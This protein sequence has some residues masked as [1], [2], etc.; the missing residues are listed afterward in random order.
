MPKATSPAHEET[1]GGGD[2]QDE[3]DEADNDDDDDDDD[4]EAD[5]ARH[6]WG[7]NDDEDGYRL[8]SGSAA[9]DSRNWAHRQ[10]KQRLERTSASSLVAELRRS[11]ASRQDFWRTATT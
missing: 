10:R 6:I 3:D 1:A 4:L 9:A 7:G 8:R 5:A 11:A 2:G